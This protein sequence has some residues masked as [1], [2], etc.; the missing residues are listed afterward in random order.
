[1]IKEEKM[2]CV[3]C[4]MVLQDKKCVNMMCANFFGNEQAPLG[5]TGY[6]PLHD[7]LLEALNQASHGKGKERHAN[8]KPFL[9]QPI[10]EIGRM[11]GP[12]YNLGQ[13]MKKC[14]EASRLP[15][16]ERK[17][18]ELLGAINYIASAVILLREN[19]GEKIKDEGC[20]NDIDIAVAK[21]KAKADNI[22]SR[23]GNLHEVS[24]I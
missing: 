21:L 14:Q 7:I 11:V 15:E 8:G 1:M 4:G 16:T 23:C 12:G 20:K 3:K 9:R 22:I 19:S 24:D 17:V 6:E 10:M 13:A 18:A 5:L 2:Y